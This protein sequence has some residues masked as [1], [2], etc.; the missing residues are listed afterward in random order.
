M[1][2]WANNPNVT[3]SDPSEFTPNNVMYY[4]HTDKQLKGSVKSKALKFL[5]NKCVVQNGNEFFIKP[6]EG[7]NSTM[8]LV[9]NGTCNCQGYTTK[10]KRGEWAHCSHTLAVEYYKKIRGIL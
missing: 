3:I 2:A 4:V 8:Y 7:Y 10:K 9:S 1:M 5:K 6:L